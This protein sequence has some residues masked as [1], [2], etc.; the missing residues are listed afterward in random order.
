M[1][2]IL[3]LS[4]FSVSAFAS[5]FTSQ[6][7]SQKDQHYLFSMHSPTNVL[8]SKNCFNELVELKDSSCLAAKVLL[9]NKKYEI[10]AQEFSGG[11]NPGAVVC[12]IAL[13]KEIRILRDVKNNENSFCVFADGSMVSASNLQ[14][15]LKD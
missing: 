15:L 7:W 4:I 14:S 3:F 8:I 9:E 2:A 5:D 1:K 6:L 11:K 12:K 13:Q 10:P